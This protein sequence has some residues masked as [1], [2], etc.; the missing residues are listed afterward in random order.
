MLYLARH[1][2][3]VWNTAGRYQGAKDSPM[4][5]RGREQAAA[6]G[7]LL[8]KLTAHSADALPAHVSPLGRA[9]E[10]AA[11]IAGHVRLD[12]RAEPRVA[13]ASLGSWDGLTVYEIEAEFPG[14]LDGAG[15]FD[16]FFRSPDG[17]GFDLL[18]ERVSAWL[19]EVREPALVVTHGMTGR[20]IRGVYLG[21]APTVML[22]LPVPQGGIHI[23]A[24]GRDT[25]VEGAE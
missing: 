6:I 11:I 20:I 22:E 15:P 21:L 10:T 16:W 4:T 3:T 19:Q 9:Q 18:V 25:F 12:H 2:E 13:E 17:E 7:R 5:P 23:L 8:A 14:A 1:G 24:D